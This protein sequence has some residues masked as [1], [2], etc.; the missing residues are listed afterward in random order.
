LTTFS[1][2]GV[3]EASIKALNENNIFEPTEIQE[4]TI[5]FLLKSSIDL[6]AQAQTGT[7]KTAA[8]GLPLI[9]KVDADNP[10]VQALILCPTRELGQQ[11]A[12]QIF[13][14]ARYTPKRI[15]VEAVY[16]GAY[17]GD[18][19]KALKRPTQILVATPGRLIDLLEK[20]AVELSHV[21]TIVLDEADEMLSMGFKKELD[22][23]LSQTQGKRNTWLFSATMPASI[24]AIIKSYMLPDAT[25]VQI[26]KNNIVNKNIDH[27]YVISEAKDKLDNLIQFLKIQ[28]A[29]R[30]LIFCVT[31]A[32]AQTLA[33]QLF[34]RNIPAEAIHGD[35]LQKDRDKVMRAFKKER[36]QILIATDLAARGLDVENLSYVV[37]YEIPDQVEYY[38]HRSGRTARAGKKGMSISLITSKELKNLQEIASTLKIDIKEYNL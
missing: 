12:K 36:V 10:S 35:L 23:I 7:G 37:H 2:L 11:I 1:D 5:P 6:I 33:K 27:K 26:D 3:S 29:N 17:I 15:Y 8:F 25:R 20:K 19:I 22:S 38:T 32:S 34:A 31:K 21:K 4:K 9:Q 18:Q 14:F 28:G 13:R 16:G 24:Q 30:G